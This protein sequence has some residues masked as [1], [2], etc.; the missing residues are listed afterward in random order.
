MD[1][2]LK[3]FNDYMTA[4]ENHNK[5]VERQASVYKQYHDANNAVDQAAKDE[6]AAETRLLPMLE[7]N[8]GYRTPDGHVFGLP[9]GELRLRVQLPEVVLSAD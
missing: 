7:P 9:N 2:I 1:P 3:A 8:R 6:K 5:A 4:I